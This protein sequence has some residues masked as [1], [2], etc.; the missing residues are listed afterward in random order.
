MSRSDIQP[1][2]ADRMSHIPK[3]EPVS[4]VGYL[5]FFIGMAMLAYGISALWLGMRD[6]MDVGGF[7]AEGGAYEIRQTCPD[8]AEL[9]MFTGIPAGI[10]GLFVAMFG[11]AKASKG[12]A[13]LLLLGWP[14][15][16]ISLGYNFLDYA[17]YPPENMG[18][19]VGWWVCG[20]VFMLMGLPALL[21][22]PMLV[23]AIP[24]ERRVPV[25]GTFLVAI[26]A[27]VV[28]MVQLVA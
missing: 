5:I 16:F 22:A 25:L 18:S 23:K 28:L 21:G 7:C 12:A 3:N 26:V 20:V 1:D 24:P 9:L 13:G 14:A 15:L 19:T 27:G 2:L 17:M 11:G 6:V 8:R 4:L 10:I